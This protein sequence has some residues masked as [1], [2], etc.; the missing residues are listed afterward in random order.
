MTR[1]TNDADIQGKVLAAELCS[2]A[3]LASRLQQLSFQLHVAERSTVGI[4]GGRQMIQILC[5]SQLHGFHRRFGGSAADHE[6][7]VI[8]RTG[9]CAKTDH[10]GSQIFDQ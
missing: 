9:G 4:A 10:F 2:N 3:G 6:C 1:Q 7:Q 8:W 5:G